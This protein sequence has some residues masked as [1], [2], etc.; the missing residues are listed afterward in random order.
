MQIIELVRMLEGS[1]EKKETVQ[2]ENARQD[3]FLLTWADISKP[4][5]LLG[6]QPK[7]TLQD[8]LRKFVA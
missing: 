1:I 6:Y 5:R 7:T 3:D 4:R 8:G 2:S